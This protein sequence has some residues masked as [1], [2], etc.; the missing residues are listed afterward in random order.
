VLYIC[1][2]LHC[3][4]IANMLWQRTVSLEIK[5]C[6]MTLR[7]TSFNSKLCTVSSH[8]S[9]PYSPRPQR[10][11]AYRL[12]AAFHWL[13]YWSCKRRGIRHRWSL[14]G[15]FMVLQFFYY[16]RHFAF[17]AYNFILQLF[18]HL[19][20][21]NPLDSSSLIKIPFTFSFTLPA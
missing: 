1:N 5:L 15:V 11:M 4:I 12:S 14:K 16:H 18:L 19:I 17:P 20:L 21:V 6:H 7:A 3:H 13:V 10:K 9:L 8:R 2:A